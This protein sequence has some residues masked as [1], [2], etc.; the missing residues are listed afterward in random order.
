MYP[1]SAVLALILSFITFFAFRSRHKTI[2]PR[3]FAGEYIKQGSLRFTLQNDTFISTF[4]SKTRRN[5]SGSGG[6]HT[7]SS[8]RSHSG[9]GRR[10]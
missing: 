9:G 8:S 10:Y 7:S 1:A 2:Q 6:S 4:I 5:T 3:H